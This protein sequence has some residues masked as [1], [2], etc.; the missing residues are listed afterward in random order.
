MKKIITILLFI[1]AFT[2]VKAQKF[3]EFAL[4]VHYPGIAADSVA[5]IPTF[6]GEPHLPLT[7]SIKRK[8]GAAA[9]DTCNHLFYWYDP[10]T[11]TWRSIAMG[12]V[13]SRPD[14]LTF[15]DS[16]LCIW[17]GGTSVCT[18]LRKDT[19]LLDRPLFAYD[20]SLNQRH[21]A[22]EGPDGLLPG[23]GIVSWESGFT[24]YISPAILRYQ[25]II[26]SFA[27]TEKTLDDPDSDP[28]YDVFAINTS[29]PFIKKGI[30][31]PSP[32]I[33][34][35][36]EGEFAMTSGFLINPG[37]TVP[38]QIT[39]Q[40]IFNEHLGPPDETTVSSTGTITKDFDNTDNPENGTKAIYVSKYNNGARFNFL[41]SST[42]TIEDGQ[43]L[44]GWIYLLKP[45]TAGHYISFR[46]FTGGTAATNS[47]SVN[48]SYGINNNDTT[49]YQRFAIPYIAFTK[50]SPTYNT[51]RATFS[52][53]DTSGAGGMHIDNI[54]LQSGIGNIPTSTGIDSI[55]L[56]KEIVGDDTLNI[57][58][59]YKNGIA[60]KCD[61]IYTHSGGGGGTE[62]D[63]THLRAD[64]DANT[65][66]ILLKKDN[67]DSTNVT[68]GYTTL[69]QNSLKQDI[70]TLY[71]STI[72]AT[73]GQ[74]VFPFSNVSANKHDGFVTIWGVLVDESLYTISGGITLTS[75]AIA[76]DKV[77]YH[78][79]K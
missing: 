72:T 31:A 70:I 63:T 26:Y 12:T 47:I 5:Y 57:R 42:Q 3:Q 33:P 36:D 4:Y 24:F 49:H 48:N 54:R 58:C 50:T 34:Q 23:T 18:N 45:L 44:T 51:L 25:N 65:A 19:T 56:R 53:Y 39:D 32:T 41:F 6:C 13:G 46:L 14:S 16:I 61:T 1:C 62:T 68:T 71:D 74:T 20:D 30:A 73:G 79:T 75:G 40:V 66:N 55:P 28:R 43:L 8:Q 35:M 2:C 10:S 11:E 60:V 77:R 21:L 7:G 69:Y 59:Q 22:I 17:Q 9:I 64:I 37:D 67:S 29:G 52:G 27:A 15:V 76:G 78:R 38:G